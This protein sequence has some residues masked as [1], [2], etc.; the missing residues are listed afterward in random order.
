MKHKKIWYALAIIV[1]IIGA[2][3]VMSFKKNT[4]TGDIK[5]GLLAPLTGDVASI[6]QGIKSAAELA[7]SEINQ[8]GGI[9]GRQIVLI[10]EDGKCDGKESVTA[11]TKLVNIDKVSAILGGAC[12]SESVSTAAIAEDAKVIMFSPL[13][14]SPDL[15]EAGDYFF[16]DYPSDSFQGA[17]AADFAV[18]TLSAKNIAVL[19][20]QSDWCQGVQKVFT[21]NVR[22]LG[23]NIVAEEKYDD[24]TSK[25]L[26]T[27]LTKIKSAKPDLVYFL[28]YTDGTILGLKQAKEIG[29]TAKMLGGDAWNDPK[30]LK[31]AGEAAEGTMYLMPTA[32][33]NEIF[34]TAFQKITNGKE[35]T[36]GSRETYDA[37]MI[38]G[39]IMKKVGSDSSEIKS[40][41]Y[42]VKDY[43]GVSG[44]ISLDKNGDL[45]SASYDIK[46]V[47][48]G[49][50]VNY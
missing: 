19:S 35:I 47:K 37:M 24:K 3:G 21:A 45:I 13:S 26:R 15:T 12:S 11:V 8:S 20:C 46:I 50:V 36:I 2:I 9:N 18:N 40:A 43:Q 1:L 23:G 4:E 7:I 14:S 41:L 30:I 16:R 33:K 42:G 44:N 5:I 29:L 32:A 49:L 38:L 27:Q 6:G 17:K 39:N 48:N 28:G 34:D 10:A 25:D 22:S 31:S